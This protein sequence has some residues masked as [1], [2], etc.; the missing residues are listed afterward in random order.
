MDNPSSP[1]WYQGRARKKKV[2]PKEKIN[3]SFQASDDMA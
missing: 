2:Y 3:D 1:S